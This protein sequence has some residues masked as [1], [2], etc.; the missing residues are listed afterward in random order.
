[1]EIRAFD[2]RDA[3]AWDALVAAAPGATFLHSRRFLSYHGNRFQDASLVIERNGNL[4]LVHDESGESH[5]LAPF[6][7]QGRAWETDDY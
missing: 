6:E 1:M 4:T 3:E 5:W 7:F 2:D